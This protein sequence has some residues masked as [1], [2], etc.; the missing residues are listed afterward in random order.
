MRFNEILTEA[1][2]AYVLKKKSRNQLFQKF[3][4]KFPEKIAH[5]IT[6]QF[7]VPSNTPHPSMPKSIKVVGY[8]SND[9]IEALIV[10]INGSTQRPGGGTYHITLSLD[11]EKGAKPVHSN[12]LIQ[13]NWERVDPITIQVSPQ[14]LK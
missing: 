5:H 4:P 11:R 8:A 3:P 9:K 13:N 2:T 7:G 6:K 14:T 12:N 1:Y 10:E